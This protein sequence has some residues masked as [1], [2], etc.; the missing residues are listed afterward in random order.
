MQEIHCISVINIRCSL[1]LNDW[2]DTYLIN[3]RVNTTWVTSMV[4]LIYSVVK[5]HSLNLCN[6]RPQRSWGKVIFS[7]AWVKNSVHGGGGM[8]GRGVCMAGG[9]CMVGVCM[10]GGVRGRGHVHGRGPCV[11]GGMHGRGGHVCQGGMCGRGGHSCVAGGHAWQI[12]WDTVLLECILVQVYVR[13]TCLDLKWSW[14]NII[15]LQLLIS[16]TNHVTI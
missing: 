2:L 4:C 14:A 5:V 9:A 15:F 6:Y 12:L 11:V 10:S 13:S 8:H 7:E 3:T 16:N 1:L